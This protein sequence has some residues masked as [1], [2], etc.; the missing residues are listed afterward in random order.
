MSLTNQEFPPSSR[1]SE[2]TDKYPAP[3]YR[4]IPSCY[5][6]SHLQT[7]TS[8]HYTRSI[9]NERVQKFV[10][11][12]P[13]LN[14]S[15]CTKSHGSSTAGASDFFHPARP[16]A[17]AESNSLAHLGTRTP[18]FEDQCQELAGDDISHNTVGKGEFC[19]LLKSYF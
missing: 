15:G 9:E 8:K 19:D 16:A 6:K 2:A 5:V 13:K 12:Q 3:T 18:N 17:N 11:F 14:Q 10:E 4:Q 1:Q 7:D